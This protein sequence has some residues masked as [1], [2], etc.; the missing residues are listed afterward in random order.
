MT[1]WWVGFDAC[2]Y[3]SIRGLTMAFVLL[4]KVMV[5]ASRREF[6]AS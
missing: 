4:G 1:V 3:E 6:A 5:P 2:G